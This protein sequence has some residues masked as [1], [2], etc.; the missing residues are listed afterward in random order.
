MH[1]AELVASAAILD[2][3]ELS[4]RDEWPEVEDSRTVH[5]HSAA[6]RMDQFLHKAYEQTENAERYV[7]QKLNDAWNVCHFSSLPK[8]LQDNDYLHC[9]HRPP[10][11]SYSA[12]IWSAFR[13]HTET[14]NIWT[15]G[16]GCLF[17]VVL[18]V[19]VLTLEPHPLQ[20]EDK[21]VF[22]SFFV[23]AIFCLGM[24][25]VYH[26]FSCHSQ[27]VGKICSRL[28][29]CG[30]ALLITGSFIPWLY[31]GFYCDYFPKVFYLILVSTLGISTVIV[32]LAERF[33]EPHCRPFRAGV[34]MAFAMSGVIPG[35]HWVYS[36]D[37]LSSVSLKVA[38]LCLILMGVLYISGAL[39]YALRIPERFF[40]GKCDVWFHSHQLFHVLVIA[41][42]MV[43]YHGFSEMAL[44][45][46]NNSQVCSADSNIVSSNSS[47]Y[48]GDL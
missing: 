29:Y 42:A 35:T 1:R 43:H 2:K 39:L 23:G 33:S 11:Q 10:L 18:A 30:I 17:F 9:C 34:F 38:L 27:R 12:C 8:W 48:F 26:T 15:H 36:Q 47:H 3:E 32:S 28:D 20:W 21:L 5:G 6:E 4:G 37:W 14:A 7:R 25:T 16:L 22:G 44:Y 45:R 19:Y 40:P 41:A 46:I 13:L 24:S 31:Y